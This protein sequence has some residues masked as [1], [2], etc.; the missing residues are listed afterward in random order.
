[1]RQFTYKIQIRN[2]LRHFCSVIRFNRVFDAFLVCDMILRLFLRLF[3]YV[4]RF[5]AVLRQFSHEIQIKA[6]SETIYPLI[7]QRLFSVFYHA[8]ND[9]ALSRI[10]LLRQ[11]LPF[12]NQTSACGIQRSLLRLLSFVIRFKVV[13]EAFL[14][15]HTN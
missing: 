11:C 12:Y 6:R 15:L 14:P 13:L 1:M 4:I 7:C 9:S 10:A 5:K 8:C 2:V 3:C